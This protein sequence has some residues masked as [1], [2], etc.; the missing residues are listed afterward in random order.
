MTRRQHHGGPHAPPDDRETCRD[1][2][3]S[4][5]D[6][7]C[8]SSRWRSRHQHPPE[9]AH[10]RIGRDP[11]LVREEDDGERE[12]LH[13]RDRVAPDGGVVGA[14]RLVERR[15]QRPR[16]AARRS[17]A[18]RSRR[19]PAASSAAASPGSSVQPATRKSEL[20]DL[21]GAAAQ[22]VEDLPAREQREPVRLRTVRA[23]HPARRAS[24]GAASR[25]E[26]SGACAACR[27][28]SA[29]GSRR[30]RSMSVASPAR[31]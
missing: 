17:T 20:S 16:A 30:T 9:R 2:P 18:P 6:A 10:D 21:D 8:H 5:C 1:M 25:R 28:G 22:V 24:G 31:A 7:V 4:V 12:L 15:A 3:R 29:S 13:A 11:R 19:A 23:R 26:S 14:P 27:S